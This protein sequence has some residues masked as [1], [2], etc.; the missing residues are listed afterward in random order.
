MTNRG[1]SGGQTR[2]VAKRPLYK[3]VVFDLYSFL[4]CCP[5]LCVTDGTVCGLMQTKYCSDPNRADRE[6]RRWWYEF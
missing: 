4:S 1:P 3:I 5:W 6:L 2:R